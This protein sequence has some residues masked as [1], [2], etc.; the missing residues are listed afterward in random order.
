MRLL[1]AGRISLERTLLERTLLERILLEPI[2]PCLTLLRPTLLRLTLPCP[3]LKRQGLPEWSRRARIWM[4]PVGMRWAL[5]G[6]S[7]TAR[8]SPERRLC[9]QFLVV[10]WRE[11][12]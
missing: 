4:L 7:G 6:Q 2:L 5:P 3:L 11:R 1:L 12:T 8:L 9:R 10:I